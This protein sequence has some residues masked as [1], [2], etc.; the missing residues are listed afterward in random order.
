[1]DKYQI[2]QSL[3]KGNSIPLLSKEELKYIQTPVGKAI[4]ENTTRSVGRPRMDDD[5]KCKP[6]DRIICEICG[7]KFVRSNRTGHNKTEYHNAFKN[8]NDKLRII[9]L[10]DKKYIK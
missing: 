1:M 7:K 2:Q 8:M 9:L 10:D 5:K 6:S 3:K 4:Y